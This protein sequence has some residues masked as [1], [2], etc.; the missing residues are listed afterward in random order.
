MSLYLLEEGVSNLAIGFMSASFGVISAVLQPILGRICDRNA[1]YSW[2][3][4]SIICAAIFAIVCF[5][6][7]FFSGPYFSIIAIGMMT[8]IANLIMP[9]VNS[10]LFYYK[11]AGEYIN[12]GIARGTGSIM[13]ALL[14]LITGNL[15]AIYGTKVVPAIG[16]VVALFFVFIICSMP[17]DLNKDTAKLSEINRVKNNKSAVA[18]TN[19]ITQN[20]DANCNNGGSFINENKTFL[21]MLLGFILLSSTHNITCNFGLQIIQNLGG[22]STNLGITMAL[23]AIVEVPVLFCFALLI[24]KLNSV[25]LLSIAAIGYVL[26]ATG[27]YL[28]SSVNMIY[29]TQF[30]QM[31]SFALFA[32]ASVYYTEDMVD[33]KD[34]TTGQALM[35]GAIVAGNVVGSSIGGFVLDA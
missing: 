33:E 29:I 10:A 21:V 12:F 7:L 20:P 16:I 1:K 30:T 3:N 34:R 23:Q 28:S 2:K 13:Y 25:K 31:L 14:S 5:L 19:E 4:M 32:S 18:D 27:F 6:M 35:A 17:Y 26:K 11:N 8:L 22:D 24:K 9:F 15:A